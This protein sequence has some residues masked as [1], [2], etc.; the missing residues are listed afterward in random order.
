MV[1]K[2]NLILEKDWKDPREEMEKIRL[3]GIW[4]EGKKLRRLGLIKKGYHP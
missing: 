3:I 4:L 2:T 1:G